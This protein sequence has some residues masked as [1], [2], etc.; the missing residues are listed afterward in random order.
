MESEQLTNFNDRLNQWISSQGFWFQLRYSITG[1][2]NRGAL[3][4]QLF[5]AGVRVLIFLAIVGIALAA[6]LVKRP[7]TN[8]FRTDLKESIMAGLSATELEMRGASRVQGQLGIA[9]IACQ[10]GDGSFFSSLEA[11]NIN[12]KMGLLDGVLG[13]WDMG[14]VGISTLNL[15][16]KAGADDADSAK[17]LADAFFRKWDSVSIQSLD[18]GD[19][20]LQW[21]YSEPTRGGIEHC[22]I[23]I[24]R[25][26][27]FM[28][29]VVKGGRFHQNWLQ[30]LEI[31]NLTIACDPNGMTF[32][33]AELRAGEG[34][35]D[36]SG[37]KV[38]GGD[39]PMVDGV[40]KIRKLPMENTLPDVLDGFVEGSISGDFKVSGSTNTAEGVSFAGKVIL[41]GDDTI[42]LREKFHVLRALSVVDYVRNYHR[43]DFRKGSFQLKTKGGGL[44]IE[45]LSI[46]TDDHFALEG[47]VSIRLPTLE[48]AQ[49][50]VAKNTIAGGT[51]L[52]ANETS[53]MDAAGKADGG[54]F[55]LRRAAMEEKKVKQEQDAIG[56]NVSLVD[57]MSLAFEA[58]DI[59]KEEVRRISGSLRYSGSLKVTLP[60]DAFERAPKLAAQLPVDAN[61]GRIPLVIP[62][63]GTLYELTLKQAEEIY[64]LGTRKD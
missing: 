53:G 6:Y 10:G 9:R 1:G 4:F 26:D 35:V 41:D 13:Q 15:D 5:N 14:A 62:I 38:I 44:V 22:S 11:K 19:A 36:F 49:A 21:G 32:E 8:R 64:Q 40:V 31:V 59:E 61:L 54:D 45:D 3:M 48:E 42:S 58:R 34:T 52:F 12:S 37:L 51:P 18:I 30:G 17:K 23:K 56:G 24:Q 7:N 43:L 25:G 29:I 60:P 16:L 28:K 57:R 2:G 33:K 39:R 20:S 63:E 55:S 27:Q 47:N 50:S 46:R